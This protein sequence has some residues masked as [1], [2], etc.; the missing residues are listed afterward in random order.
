MPP[1]AAE[2]KVLFP[3][4]LELWLAVDGVVSLL[5]VDVR[6]RAFGTRDAGLPAL[7]DGDR[8]EP[9]RIHHCELRGVKAGVRR[10]GGGVGEITGG[11]AGRV[12]LGDGHRG[13]LG[14]PADA[15]DALGGGAD[16]RRKRLG[17][18]F[19]LLDASLEDGGAGRGTVGPRE[20]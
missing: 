7:H 18:S 20:L 10:R 15:A 5:A 12:V 19:Q 13:G 11:L 14:N 17:Q 3:T 1:V 9:D 4:A 2:A 6:A 16:G 8:G